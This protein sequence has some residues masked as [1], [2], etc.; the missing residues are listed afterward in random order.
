ML[1]RMPIYLRKEIY[2]A[3]ILVQETGWREILGRIL[4]ITMS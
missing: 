4:T 2:D 1:M 3:K